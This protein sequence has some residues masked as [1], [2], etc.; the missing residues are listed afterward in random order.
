M[1]ELKDNVLHFSFPQVFDNA[2]VSIEFQRTLRIP[3]D[4][5][6]YPLPPGLG[7][8]PLRH[9]DDF[10]ENLP[11][12]W[13]QHGGVMMPMYQSEAMW[14]MFQANYIGDRDATYPCAI[15]IATGK[16][17][18]VSGQP[19]SP[20]L[21]RR[22]QDYAVVPGQPWLDGYCVSKGVIRQFVAM[23]LG[24]G[25][26]AEEQLTGSADVGGLQIAVFP[27]KR[28]VFERRFPKIQPGTR[29]EAC[30][31]C[32]AC[33]PSPGMGLAAGGKMRQEIYEDE[34]D[35]SDWDLAAGSRCFVHIVNSMVWSAITSSSPPLP[36]PTAK[37]YARA[38]L[39]WFD[40][41][42]DDASAVDGASLL[43]ALKSVKEMGEQRGLAPLPENESVGVDRVIKL[44]PRKRDEVRQGQG[45]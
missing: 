18:A 10:A 26:T 40:Y 42:R 35:L 23:P 19:W 9:V 17:N 6:E 22:P 3:D 14:I 4:G 36:P 7:A 20:G 21:N 33:A 41:Y 43:A 16:I 29:I 1:I 30:L 31:D 39:P 38:H 5:C 32:L 15:K 37:Q 24:E 28:E 34:F 11:P 25:Y 2:G 44:S 8:F 12:T 27:M 45:W 13:R